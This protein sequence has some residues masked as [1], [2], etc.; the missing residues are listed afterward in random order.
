MQ[1]FKVYKDLMKR[2]GYEVVL[3]PPREVAKNKPEKTVIF[4]SFLKT[5]KGRYCGKKRN[6]EAFGTHLA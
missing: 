5:G 1:E 2:E 6:R 3:T 4:K